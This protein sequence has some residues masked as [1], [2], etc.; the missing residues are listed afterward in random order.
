MMSW[1]RAAL[2]WKP[3]VSLLVLGATSALAHAP[4]FFVWLL[5][6]T[7]GPALWLVWQRQTA[8]G[9]IWA[10][11]LFALA[12]FAVGMYWLAAP[13]F[14]APQNVPFGL[15]GSVIGT[16]VAVLG[17][18]GAIAGCF[19]LPVGLTVYGLNQKDK[20]LSWFNILVI[21]LAW[22]C[23]DWLRSWVLTGLP[24]NLTAYVWGWS[25]TMMQSAAW[26]GPYG[27]TLVT[28]VV[29]FGPA[30]ALKQNIEPT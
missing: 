6:L 16:P 11:W 2:S 9:C 30:L 26:I 4:T 28:A 24:W 14:V 7:F 15:M 10:V 3:W 12:H 18:P 1:L 29:A 8:I 20:A 25:L 21:A 13:L 22:A 27:L 19:A 23:G 17:I 5:P